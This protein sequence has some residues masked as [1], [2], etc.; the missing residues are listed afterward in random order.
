MVAQTIDDFSL[1]P[2]QTE[3]DALDIQ[4]KL[5]L[6]KIL[7]QGVPSANEDIS[8]RVQRNMGVLQGYDDLEAQ[9]GKR[10]ALSDR[11]EQ[12]LL[13]A[14]RK[15]NAREDVLAA[16]Q[17]PA[18]RKEALAQYGAD[19][20]LGRRKERM[21]QFLGGGG[22]PATLAP[23]V[24]MDDSTVP[25]YPWQEAQGGGL[26][27]VTQARIN[28]LAASGDPEDLDLAK[29][30]A[31][32][33]KPHGTEGTYRMDLEGNMSS[34]PGAVGAASEAEAAKYKARMPFGAPVKVWIDGKEELLPP[35]Q[36][37]A[38]L[39]SRTPANSP[40][41][42]A[43]PTGPGPTPA[44]ASG[45]SSPAS[46]LSGAVGA[47]GAAPAPVGTTTPPRGQMQGPNAALDG[48][49]DL[50]NNA[51]EEARLLVEAQQKGDKAGVELH[52]QNGKELEIGIRAL[53]KDRHGR[54]S[55]PGADEAA[56]FAG[57]A[58][59]GTS[60]IPSCRRN[61]PHRDSVSGSASTTRSWSNTE[62]AAGAAPYGSEYAATSSAAAK[63][64]GYQ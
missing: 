6:A 30:Y 33:T 60:S 37:D 9:T 12:S 58:G 54:Q 25:G 59:R 32:Q 13:E 61:R 8:S 41:G 55:S 26:K 27:G 22:G 36:A 38:Y 53:E 47:S 62:S 24:G 39:R 28:A 57:R 11:Y 49:R 43:A 42:A 10:K 1:D 19:M 14:L 63:T 23:N 7:R 44:P 21:D 46:V 40:A 35:D 20:K 5:A 56:R 34:I 18:L 17:S 4:R 29:F 64:A 48:M 3:E 45:P 15:G 52:S 31:G 51:Q 2:F 50:L 16:A